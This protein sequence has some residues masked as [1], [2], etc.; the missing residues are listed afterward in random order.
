T[1]FLIIGHHKPDKSGDDRTTL[2]IKVH[3]A[4]GALEKLINPLAKNNINITMIRSK[5]A[6]P[7]H[8]AYYFFLDLDC[9]QDDA[10]FLRAKQELETGPMEIKI[11]GSYPKAPI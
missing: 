3:D 11:L 2:L 4:P 6:N 8:S 10:K 5:P 7:N 9:Y 1:R